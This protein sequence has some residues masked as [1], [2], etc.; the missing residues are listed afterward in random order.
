MSGASAGQSVP[1]EVERLSEHGVGGRKAPAPPA[2]VT[3]NPVPLG[4]D[5]QQ[6]ISEQRS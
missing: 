5:R 4:L 3:C 2:P 6:W 1:R